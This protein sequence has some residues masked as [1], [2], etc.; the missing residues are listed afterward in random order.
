MAV[1]CHYCSRGVNPEEVRQVGESIVMCFDCHER[2]KREVQKFEIPTHCQ[3]GC[4]LSV[5]L[6]AAAGSRFFAHW[7]DGCYQLL[8]GA[9]DEKYVPLRKDLFAD[10]RFG[11]DRK[12][13]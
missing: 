8:C 5:A 12:L 11:W 3:G 2:H 10:T 9:C 13:K 6:L 4:N 1:R 7:K